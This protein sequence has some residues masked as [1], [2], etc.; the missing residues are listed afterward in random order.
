MYV[1]YKLS[2]FSTWLFWILKEFGVL[3]AQYDQTHG[4]YCLAL[5]QLESVKEVNAIFLPLV[6]IFSHHK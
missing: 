1:S 5:R 2:Y 4:L 3:Q 6:A